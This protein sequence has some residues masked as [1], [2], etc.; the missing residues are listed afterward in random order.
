VIEFEK[1]KFRIAGY[2]NKLP[3]VYSILAQ[4]LE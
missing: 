2:D 3:L 4:K 1:G